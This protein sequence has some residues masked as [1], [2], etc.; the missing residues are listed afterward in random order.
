M[1]AD[2]PDKVDLNE[3]KAQFGA[4]QVPSDE[5]FKKLIDM[6]ALSFYP[7]DGLAGGDA[8]KPNE[9]GHDKV[10]P[11]SVNPG[12]GVTVGKA[13]VEVAIGDTSVFETKTPPEGP[14]T[15]S[16]KSPKDNSLKTTNGLALQVSKPVVIST[17][18]GK[19]GINI[20][21]KKG[22]MFES[23]SGALSLRVDAQ[24]LEI[25]TTS[26]TPAKQQVKIKCKKGGGL[27][28][29]DKGYLQP[30]IDAFLK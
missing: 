6:A 29:D 1:G 5:D 20:D 27:M 3:L 7:G 17:A 14:K 10:T 28:I 25:L 22:L 12:K 11:L 30:D 13:G 16:L 19:V 15:M 18:N 23:D 2:K 26:E 24:S 21:L 9:A 4:W 8:S